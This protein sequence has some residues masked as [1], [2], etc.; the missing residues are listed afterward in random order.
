MLRARVLSG[1]RQVTRTV[2]I[3]E[4]IFSESDSKTVTTSR[5]G[6]D[7]LSETV[8]GSVVV[9]GFYRSLKEKCSLLEFDGKVYSIT[10]WRKY[11]RQN[12]VRAA[13]E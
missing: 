10:A 7:H 2:S 12:Q 9:L 13:L 11:V 5:D 4:K 1:L 3:W 8:L 6:I